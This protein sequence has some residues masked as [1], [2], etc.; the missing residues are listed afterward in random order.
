MPGW[1]ALGPLPWL[2]LVAVG[3][4]LLVRREARLAREVRDAPRRLEREG[5]ERTRDER[6]CADRLYARRG[7]VVPLPV[8][9]RR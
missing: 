1:L 8:R 9:R 4:L 7:D 5:W 6:A 3:I 2:L